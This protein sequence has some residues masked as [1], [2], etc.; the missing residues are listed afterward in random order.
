VSAPAPA[1]EEKRLHPASLVVRWLKIVPQM[2]AGGIGLAAT[3]EYG[4][5]QRFILFA[6]FAGLIGALFALVS[7]WRFL[8]AIGPGEIVIEKGVLRRRRRVIPF[9]RVQDV[10]IE[11]GLIARLFGTARVRVETGGAA[12]DEGELDMVALAEAHALR[13]RV[14]LNARAAEAAPE[15][16]AEEPVLFAMDGQRLLLSGLFGFSL[17]FLAAL[18]AL[19]Q[20]LDQFGIV[21]WDE[22]VTAERAEAASR[23]VTLWATLML[24]TLI[25]LAGL[26]AGMVRTV[27]QDFGFR[28]TRTEAGLRRRRGLFTLSEVVI[29][30]GRTQAALIESGPVSRALGWYRLSFQT[31]GADRKE[32]G[33]QVAA[34]FA[35]MAEILPILAEAGFPAPPPPAAYRGGPR[36]ALIRWGAPWAALALA[37]AVAAW[38]IDLRAAIGAIAFVLLGI[39]ALLHWRVHRHAADADALYVSHGLLKRRLAV[40]PYGKTQILAVSRGPLQRGLRLATLIVDTAGAQPMRGIRMIDL[41]RDEADAGADRLHAAFLAARAARKPRARRKSRAP[42]KLRAGHG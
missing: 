6:M 11:R 32:G 13:D 10:A 20:Q 3:S 40:M 33:V 31:L 29:P 35:R 21:D 18:A 4:G 5:L 23:L 1:P 15:A 17:V 36:R 2:L 37:A 9:D 42:R 41:D 26:A 27:L 34:P 30:L 19:V 22:W 38:L 7:W 14:R 8:Y 25:V 24:A 16:R 39:A 28:L 12:R